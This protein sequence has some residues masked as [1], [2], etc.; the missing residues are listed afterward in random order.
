MTQEELRDLLADVLRDRERVEA[1]GVDWYDR[2]SRAFVEL[3]I[4]CERRRVEAMTDEERVRYYDAMA[5]IQRGMFAGGGRGE[6]QAVAAESRRVIV[7]TG[8]LKKSQDDRPGLVWID[9]VRREARGAR[10]ELIRFVDVDSDTWRGLEF[11]DYSVEH[12][13]KEWDWDEDKRLQLEARV[14][15]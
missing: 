2:V 4:E 5:E 6:R 3:A 1:H 9:A 15:R 13:G 10:G 12:T 8:N 14:R 7:M 11:D